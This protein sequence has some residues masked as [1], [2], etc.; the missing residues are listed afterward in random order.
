MFSEDSGILLIIVFTF[1]GRGYGILEVHNPPISS[2]SYSSSI[3]SCSL[4]L[5]D[6]KLRF[7]VKNCFC[8]RRLL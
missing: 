6:A 8:L 3:V 2:G 4:L 7:L 1:G 5:S